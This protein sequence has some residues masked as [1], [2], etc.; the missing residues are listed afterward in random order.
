[1]PSEYYKGIFELAVLETCEEMLDVTLSGEYTRILG[2]SPEQ[3]ITEANAEIDR[4]I[5]AGLSMLRNLQSGIRPDYNHLWLPLLHASWYHLR[6]VN[7]LQ[8]E[9]TRRLKR[10]ANSNEIRVM[11][12]GCGTMPVM[13]AIALVLAD[14]ENQLTHHKVVVQN[15]DTSERMKV[16]G[17]EMRKKLR[18]ILARNNNSVGSKRLY[19]AIRRI[20]E[21][22]LES[23]AD[24][25]NSDAHL[26][27]AI[28]CIYDNKGRTEIENIPVE[29]KCITLQRK[30]AKQIG[31]T[32]QQPVTGPWSGELKKLTKFRKEKIGFHCPYEPYLKK[33]V[34]WR[35]HDFVLVNL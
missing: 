2:G 30:K 22:K 33:L 19:G 34:E 5:S 3:L 18:E 24:L 26:L 8:P 9:L 28:H 21:V 4:S 29:D 6:H 16:M 20:T 14:P 7:F 11:D 17:H 32:A 12:F 23:A 10:Y 27:T 13:W 15:Y 25:S 35:H 1:M 31:L